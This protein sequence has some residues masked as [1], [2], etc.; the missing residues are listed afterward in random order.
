MPPCPRVG[1]LILDVFFILIG[2]I[3]A[4][5]IFIMFF[6]DFLHVLNNISVKVEVLVVCII[7]FK[8]LN[9]LQT[10]IFIISLSLSSAFHV[11]T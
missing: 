3:S 7:V 1:L 10:A 4:D 11:Q 6:L 9:S 8:F 2:Q 5:I